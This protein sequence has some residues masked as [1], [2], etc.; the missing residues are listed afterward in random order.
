M[1][2]KKMEPST[3]EA[4]V[5]CTS[6]PF[7]TEFKHEESGKPLMSGHFLDFAE[8]QEY[9]TDSKQ[10]ALLKA[11]RDM[12]ITDRPCMVI[13]LAPMRDMGGMFMGEVKWE[14]SEEEAKESY[15]P[16]VRIVLPV[17]QLIDL[18]NIKPPLGKSIIRVNASVP[19]PIWFQAANL[20][21]HHKGAMGRIIPFPLEQEDGKFM[22][23]AMRV[24]P[25]EYK[26]YNALLTECVSRDGVEQGFFIA[27][28]FAYVVLDRR[29]ERLGRKIT[30]V[31]N[32]TVG[33]SITDVVIMGD[34]YM[35]GV[36][37]ANSEPEDF[38]DMKNQ[39]IY[40]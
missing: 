8:F 35:H 37:I 24:D 17:S 14:E 23:H 22:Y 40:I 15:P 33:K 5:P 30:E 12:K 18:K 38:E 13:D 4:H 11:L 25:D 7:Y 29:A 36:L 28:K 39:F 32:A 26:E 1:D 2:E 31:S 19:T 3:I 21:L 16:A 6:Q 34:S 27:T 10:K 9:D 20:Q